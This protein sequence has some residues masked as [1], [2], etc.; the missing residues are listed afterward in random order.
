MENY[1]EKRLRDTGK[2]RAQSLA[3]RRMARSNRKLLTANGK[4]RTSTLEFPAAFE[5]WSGTY[6]K[7][8][9]NARWLR[10]AGARPSLAGSY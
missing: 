1:T 4:H 10:L 8:K 3:V 2:S 6:A 9:A 7:M 5:R